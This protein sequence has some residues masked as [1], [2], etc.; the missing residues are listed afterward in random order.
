MGREALGKMIRDRQRPGPK[1]AKSKRARS[2]SLALDAPWSLHDLRRTAA[3]LMADEGVAESII[4]RCLS[5]APPRLV[6]TYQR[7]DR[8][9]EMRAAFD[10]LGTRL[11]ASMPNLLP[12]LR[13]RLELD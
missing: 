1:S 12:T 10:R 9:T 7:S 13:E 11:A 8:L 3:T 4:E 6:R 5:H 2:D